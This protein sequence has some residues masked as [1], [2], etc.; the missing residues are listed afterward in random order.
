M[1]T[2][3]VNYEK[4]NVLYD[5]NALHNNEVNAQTLMPALYALGTLLKEANATSNGNRVKVSVNINS[6]FNIDICDK[7]FLNRVRLRKVTFAKGDIIKALIHKLQ[8]LKK[9]SMKTEYIEYR[10]LEELE[11]RHGIPQMKLPFVDN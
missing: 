7:I 8:Y 6:L 5:G 11:H 10:I 4:F 2:I 1:V 9:E 3:R